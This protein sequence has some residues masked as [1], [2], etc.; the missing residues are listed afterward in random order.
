PE[1]LHRS[2]PGARERTK[3]WANA[4][5]AASTARIAAAA[6]RGPSQRHRYQKSVEV[7]WKQAGALRPIERLVFCGRAVIFGP[8]RLARS[9]T[10]ASASGDISGERAFAR[11]RK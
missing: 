10:S 2:L 11:F 1:F 7:V 4:I 6:E 3:Y 9:S 5:I 8:V